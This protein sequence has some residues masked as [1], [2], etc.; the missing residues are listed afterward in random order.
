MHQ[1]AAAAADLHRFLRN[2][3]RGRGGD[4]RGESLGDSSGL[5]DEHTSGTEVPP[6]FCAALGVGFDARH[7]PWSRKHGTRRTWNL[8]LPLDKPTLE[9][10][11][12]SV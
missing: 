6:G 4:L 11:I 5:S 2:G 10:T 9:S 3:A 7:P 12:V 8:R 1:C